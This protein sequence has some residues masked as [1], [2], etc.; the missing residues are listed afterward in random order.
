MRSRIFP[1]ELER[2]VKRMSGKYPAIPPEEHERIIGVILDSCVLHPCDGYS[3]IDALYSEA[4]RRGWGEFL[5][6]PAVYVNERIMRRE[7]LNMARLARDGI[8]PF[9]SYWR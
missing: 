7:D 2:C 6:N 5:A 1:K 9:S 8:Q 4:D 3:G